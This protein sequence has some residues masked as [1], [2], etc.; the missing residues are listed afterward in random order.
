MRASIA[1]RVA[2][3]A[4]LGV[5]GLAA[6][7]GSVTLPTQE[8]I[9]GGTGANTQIGSRASV[10][11][12]SPAADLQITGGTPVEVNWRVVAT[13]NFATVEIFF[14]PD[15]DPDNGNEFF[16]LR[17]VP[18]T[19]TTALL[20]T[21]QLSSQTYSI[22]VRLIE[23]NATAATG[24]AP[25]QLIVN[26]R[27]QFFFTAP[28]DNLAFDRS[29]RVTPRID[30]AWQ[31]FDPDSTVTVEI[32]LTREGSSSGAG[33]LKL[34]ES[35]SQ[36]GDTFSFDL[37]TSQLAAGRYRLQAVVNDGLERFSFFAPGAFTIRDRLAG[38]L[39]LRNLGDPNSVLVGAVF[40][41]VNPG[42]NAGSFVGTFTDIDRDGFDDFL[43]M[44]QFGKPRF[45]ANVARTGV[46]EVYM[47]YGRQ[48]RFVGNIP[49][50]S[51][52]RLFRGEVFEGVP[53]VL[54]PI[55]PSRGLTSFTVLSDWT[56]DGVKEFAFGL[57][58]T[59]SLPVALLDTAGYFRSGAVVI[60]DGSVLRPDF[61]FVGGQ[62]IPLANIGT[63]P[64]QPWVQSQCPESFVGP[65]APTPGGIG[66]GITSY[67]RHYPQLSTATTPAPN[68]GG[69]RLGC[70][71][72]SNDVGDQFGES[73]ATYDFHGLIMSAPNRDP[74]TAIL[75]VALGG[76]PTNPIPTASVPG[77]GVI[78]V[79][80]NSTFNTF[81]PWDPVS[82]PPD[83]AQ[84]NYRANQTHANVPFLP[85]GGP[86]HYSVDEIR[87]FNNNPLSISPGYYLDPDD[88]PDPPC[89][90]TSAAGAPNPATT[91]RFW[92]SIPGGR[93]SGARP[94]RD[95]NGDGFEDIV[96]GHPLTN[97]GAGA[98]FVIFGRLQ[99]L[100]SGGELQV[101]ELGLPIV[102][103]GQSP[104]TARVF[105]G[106]RILG[107]PGTRLGSSQDSAGDFNGDGLTDVLIGSPLLN[108]RQG[109]A[110]VFFGSREVISLTQAEIPYTELP[111]RGLGVILVGET[112][113]DLAGALVRGVSDVDG[114]GIDDI[115]IVAPNKSVRLDLD[116]DGVIDVDRQNCGAVYVVYGARDL[117]GTLKLSDIGTQKVPGAMFIG[118]NSGDFLGAGLGLQGDRSNGVAAAG[119]IDGDGR[120]DLVL[121]S[122]SAS[123]RNRVQAGEVYLIYGRGN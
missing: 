16:A 117:K 86:Y 46:G 107:A 100:M 17:N 73:I 10:S 68:A 25:G 37:V 111:N 109:G 6:G 110:A 49:F 47:M 48:E 120:T 87:L 74:G 78:S 9:P 83:N 105:D 58:F 51:T 66:G 54:D 97:D 121:G 64:F 113:G 43:A 92:S 40:E 27:P 77:G 38:Y 22:R 122:V 42:D 88:N 60:C 50:N 115:A 80:Y 36:T 32:F 103:Q 35:T 79:F 102:P 70:R 13:T 11:V 114:D 4:G 89:Q 101:E 106:V 119:D 84:F 72:S 95:F 90:T 93:L 63:L 82:T 19:D 55:R 81:Y 21:S 29:N 116:G 15:D 96:V 104:G 24:T 41:G 18:V 61:G 31:V 59:D 98:C 85:H 20:D 14:D 44:A 62:S 23:Q 65:K 69:A 56:L 3:A 91:T 123:P 1:S 2:W 8:Y 57:P 118:R 33:D 34:R 12:V 30:V 71:F 52:G 108:N 39:D 28:R 7:C 112:E 53:E 26:Q 5:V 94:L 67:H 75:G 99:A 76:T 45:G